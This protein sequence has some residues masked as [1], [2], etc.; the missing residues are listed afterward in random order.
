MLSKTSTKHFGAAG[1]LLILAFCLTYLLPL[2]IRPMMIPDESRYGEIPREMLVS[3]NWAVPH[4][5]DLRYFEKPPLGY[6]LNA[7]SIKVFGEN[8]FAVRLPSALATGL[9]AWFIW[10][11]LIRTG[12]G[13]RTALVAAAVF[14][15]F[16]EVLIVGTL[17]VLD[18]P[19]SLFL[20]GAMVLFYLAS[21]A[22][23][24]TP[25]QRN[26]LLGSGILFGLAFLTKGFLAI[27]L[28]GLVLLTYLLIQKRYKLLWQSWLVVTSTIITVLPWAVII[29]LREADFWHY[30]IFEEHIRR[31]LSDNAQHAAPM[32]YYL[33]ILPVVAFPWAGFIP[34]AIAG[35]R[36]GKDQ[37]NLLW[38]C[39][40][41][42]ALPFV[43]FSISKGKLAT[44]ILPC[45]VPAAVLITMGILNYVNAGRKRLLVLGVAINVGMLILGLAALLYFQYVRDGRPVYPAGESGKLIAMIASLSVAILLS[46]SA[47]F[48]RSVYKSIAAIALS[49]VVMFL[50][51]N[52]SMP[53]W[54][55][56][57][58]SPIAMF[59]QIKATLPAQTTLVSDANLVRAVAWTFKRTDIYLLYEGE[60]G[61]GLS[62]PEH[63]SK[64]LG[65][66]GLGKLLTQQRDGE[67]KN[68]I[69]VF[70]EDPCPKDL[71]GLLEQHGATQH[72]NK[73]YSAFV[74][75]PAGQAEKNTP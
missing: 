5:I 41:W 3:G 31:F 53:T 38:Y 57:G 13:Q 19:F 64:K 48:Y 22:A 18:N 4:L 72:S 16:T 23:E 40:L 32:Y 50:M 46:L 35:I 65:V 52:S 24:A 39:V 70:C 20:S 54:A 29:H 7:V 45:L 44:Y 34:A 33:A 25:A 10:L 69:A 2:G 71:T 62:Y 9:S 60:L 55:L 27:A 6:W 21:E 30:F 47:V 43:F 28:P 73:N 12:Y 42:F 17:A 74:I 56:E 51:L 11:L 59:T 14:L 8:I 36:L 67:S 68:T 15:S 37:R 75:P 61:Y 66:E 58:K 49:I 26:Y 1:F 63:R